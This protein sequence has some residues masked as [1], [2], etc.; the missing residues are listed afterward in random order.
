M[1]KR[2]TRRVPAVDRAVRLLKLLKGSEMR[3]TELCRRTGLHKSTVYG[4]LNTL[5]AHRLVSRN[6]VT[7]RYR[8]SYGLLELGNAVLAWMDLRRMARGAIEELWRQTGETVVLHLLDPQG[9]LIVDRE[10]SP[11]EL[12]VAAPIG[13]RLPPFAGAVYKVFLA[14]LPDE[15]VSRL[16]RGAHLPR[17]TPRSITDPEVYLR[18]IQRVRRLGYAIDDEEYLPAVRAASAPILDPEGNPIASLSVVGVSVRMDT[19]RLREIGELVR[20]AARR[21]SELL[22]AHQGDGEHRVPTSGRGVRKDGDAKARASARQ[23]QG[24]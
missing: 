18:E 1:Q 20:A 3:L 24:P 4:I 11:H 6:P 7:K 9:S 8:L 17:F 19:R 22:R 5:E 10:E 2:K 16:L 15:E 23:R 14:S 21:V 12:K 13:K